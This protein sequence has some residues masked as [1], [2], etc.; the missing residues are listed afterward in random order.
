MSVNVACKKKPTH[1]AV[2]FIH[3]SASLFHFLYR[4]V[5][6]ELDFIIDGGGYWFLPV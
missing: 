6:V 4:S 1:K 5:K 3:I 2:D